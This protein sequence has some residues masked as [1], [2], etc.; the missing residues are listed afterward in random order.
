MAS[1]VHAGEG[2]KANRAPPAMRLLQWQPRLHQAFCCR[3]A[4]QGPSPYSCRSRRPAL[5]RRPGSITVEAVK[6]TS[7][8]RL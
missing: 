4:G 8:C 3:S 5:A 2:V 6:A 7:L 1:G